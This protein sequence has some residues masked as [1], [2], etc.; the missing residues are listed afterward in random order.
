[1]ITSKD[2]ISASTPWCNFSNWV[3]SICV[4]TF[5]LEMGQ[6]LEM[7]YPSHCKLSDA[8]RNNVCYLSFPDSNSGVMG[9]VQF[10]FRIRSSSYTANLSQ[11]DALHEYNSNCL[12][13]DQTEEGYMFG[14]VYFRQVK[15][16][17]LKRG[18]FQKS[19][20]VLSVLPLVGLFTRVLE[21]LAPEYFECGPTSLEAACH[22]IDQWPPPSPGNLLVLPL[23]GRLLHTRL[24]S[25]AD[26][27]G[28][29]APT[30]CLS[31]PV[32]NQVQVF[33]VLSGLVYQLHLLWELVLT[34]EPVVVMAATPTTAANTVH[35]L[36]SLIAPLKYCGDFRPFFTIHDTEFKEYTTRTTSP[37][38]VMLGV[39]NPFFAKTLHHWPH[40]VRPAEE[41]FYSSPSRGR[42]GRKQLLRSLD[43]KPGVYTKFKPHLQADK[44]LS[45]VLL[46]GV[47]TGRPLEVQSA[48]LR[49]HLL[50]LTQS[51]M[52]PLERYVASLMPL[53]RNISPYKSTPSLR[54]FN[55]DEFLATLDNAGPHLTSGI[56]GD[57]EG[58]YR[59]FFRCINFSAWFNDRYREISAKL[60]V[61]HLQTLSESDLATWARSRSEVET[62]E[63]LLRVTTA[64]EEAKTLP[65]E[66]GTLTKLK[67]RLAALLMEIPSDLRS[68]VEPLTSKHTCTLPELLQEHHNDQ[69]PNRLP[70]DK[71]TL[72]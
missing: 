68:I 58:L 20:V 50:E 53:H 57:W 51:F 67:G 48:L 32:P 29:L 56:K 62:V 71:A 7:I 9:N 41:G 39:T 46:R 18:Y 16:R 26:K 12:P 59:R 33:G 61:L 65:V 35:A 1:M 30:P 34:A 10:S 28:L 14:Y 27:A 42:G 44:S 52:I 47:Q 64:L 49:R 21:I 15:D 3:H 2:E 6:A 45:K 60:A 11:P 54:Q 8:E 72:D 5:D 70:S 24:P 22:H 66:P 13:S 36:R 63:L 23:L 17:S 25:T 4:V 55:P 40:V 38:T 43:H 37:P 69:T 19:V 31:V